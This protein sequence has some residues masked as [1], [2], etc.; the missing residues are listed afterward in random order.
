M[1]N[2]VSLEKRRK[3]FCVTHRHSNVITSCFG[4]IYCARCGQ[5]IGDTLAGCYENA[6]AVLVD[7]GCE[8]CKANAKKLTRHDTALLPPAHLKCVKELR[9]ES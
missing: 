5:Q 6:S 1:K 2:K 7:H 4:Y 8:E 3:I 9:G